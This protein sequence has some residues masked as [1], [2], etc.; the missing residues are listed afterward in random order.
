M[1]KIACTFMI[2]LSVGNVI[3]RC[4]LTDPRICSVLM[5]DQNTGKTALAIVRNA[6]AQRYRHFALPS[7]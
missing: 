1:T 7:I 2:L 3:G 5:S 4:L 6:D